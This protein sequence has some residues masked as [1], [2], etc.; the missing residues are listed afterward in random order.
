MEGVW[1]STAEVTV[2]LDSHIEAEP[3]D[4]SFCT[5]ALR[6]FQATRGW[7]EPILARIK[8]DTPWATEFQR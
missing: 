3:T 8:E 5:P 6:E 4:R 7:L 1:R 2:F